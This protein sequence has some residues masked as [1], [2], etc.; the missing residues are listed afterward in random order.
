MQAGVPG[1][2]IMVIANQR[3]PC[4]HYGDPTRACICPEAALSRYRKRF[5]GP[6]TDRIDR[7]VE[8]LPLSMRSWR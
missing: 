8:A 5:S 7:H 1:F 3:C 2:L 4:G 6:P